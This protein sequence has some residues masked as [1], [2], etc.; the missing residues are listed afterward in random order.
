MK[1]GTI[2]DMETIFSGVKVID[3][4]SNLAGPGATALLADFGAEVI[5]VERPVA[6]DDIRGIAPRIE[7]QAI[8]STFTNRGK[9]SVTLAL[10]DPDSIK[11]LRMMIADADVIIES[12]KP[13]AMKKFGLDYDSVIQTKPDIIYCSISACGQTGANSKKPGFDIIAQGMSGLMDLTGDP[14]G[15]PTKSGSTVGD[16]IGG[17]NAFGAIASAL[18]YRLRKGEG[19]YIDIALLDGL[20]AIN[21]SI[22]GAA[23]LGMDPHRI[24]NHHTNMAP[25]GVFNGK[26]GQSVIIAAYT[27]SMWPKLCQVMGRPD[28]IEDPDLSSNASRVAN[29]EKLIRTI[30]LWLGTFDDIN[31]AASLLATAGVACCKTR[32]T[33][34]VVNDPA[35]W[36]RGTLVEVELPPSFKKYSTVKRRGPWIKFSKTPAK[37]SRS[38]DLGEHN[39]EV[40]GKYG[41]SNR[42]IDELQNR[43]N[44]KF[45]KQ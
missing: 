33:K 25:Y 16:Y 13:G 17:I 12:F 29:L 18:Y 5:K 2:R 30:E 42:D 1:K 21:S 40:L 35:L 38:C 14:S 36:E 24:G 31:D 4:T 39:Y 27:G 10:D 44:D 6:G 9:K 32:T 7:G 15:P 34:E 23:T 22:E 8:F 20:V 41:L 26:N 11:I 19:Q 45:K 3:F 43:W 28:C 37:I